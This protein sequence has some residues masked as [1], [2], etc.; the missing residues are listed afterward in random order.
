MGVNALA[1]GVLGVFL[2]PGLK[3]WATEYVNLKSYEI[4]E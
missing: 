3:P 2:Y 4:S 1:L